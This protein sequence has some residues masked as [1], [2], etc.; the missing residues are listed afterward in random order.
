MSELGEKSAVPQSGPGGA[1]PPGQGVP[2]APPS[3]PFP[4]HG[5]RVPGVSE[6]A[7]RAGVDP[8]FV[9]GFDRLLVCT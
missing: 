2:G 4:V 1:P 6:A 3:A 9:S 7:I 5:A 8:H